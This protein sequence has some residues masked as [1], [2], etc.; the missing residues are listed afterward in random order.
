MSREISSGSCPEEKIQSEILS[1]KNR[2]Q[3]FHHQIFC[4]INVTPSVLGAKNNK[5]TLLLQQGIQ[6]S[7]IFCKTWTT[8]SVIIS[9]FDT[10]VTCNYHL[11]ITFYSFCKIESIF[12]L[13][14]LFEIYKIFISV[15]YKIIHKI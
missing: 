15:W 7:T 3:N 12:S 14:S 11:E 1:D 13:L 10:C 4:T 2:S 5:F 6:F 9:Y 8:D